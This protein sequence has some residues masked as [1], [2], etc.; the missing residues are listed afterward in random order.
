[1][2]F[3]FLFYRLWTTSRMR[4]DT[5]N[6]GANKSSRL[7]LPHHVPSWSGLFILGSRTLCWPISLTHL[8][9]V[10]PQQL[11]KRK[12]C[13]L[14]LLLHSLLQLRVH[15]MQ[16]L[17]LKSQMLLQLLHLFLTTIL[18]CTPAA[19]ENHPHLGMLQLGFLLP[20]R[21]LHRILGLRRFLCL[22]YS[23][24]V[25]EADPEPAVKQESSGKSES[26]TQVSTFLLKL[27]FRLE[28]YWKKYAR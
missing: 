11:P 21:I 16:R 18:Q 22:F 6:M 13:P 2:L 15:L 8:Q 17:P 19:R 20:E 27:C 5:P 4:R 7:S 1:M 14:A 25:D 9:Q 26:A 12:T 24:E 3:F 28:C 10:Q 23:S